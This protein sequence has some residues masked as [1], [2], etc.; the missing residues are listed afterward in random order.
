MLTVE[1]EN[2]LE[3]LRERMP[4]FNWQE[5]V[6]QVV[7]LARS[8]GIG[9]KALKKSGQRSGSEYRALFG[10]ATETAEVLDAALHGALKK[11]VSGVGKGTDSTKKTADAEERAEK[12]LRTLKRDHHLP[13]SEWIAL[14]K[15]PAAKASKNFADPVHEAAAAQDRHPRLH[16]DVQRAIELVFELA[17]QAIDLY[18]QHKRELGV[19][20]FVDQETYALQLLSRP[21]VQEQLAGELDLVLIDEFQ[22]TSPIQLAIFLRLAEVAKRSI[23]VGDQKQAI[24][25]FRGADPALMDAAIEEILGGK[26]PE[27]LPKSYRSRPGLVHFSSKLFAP[28]FALQG[29][30]AA[31]VKLVPSKEHE[32]TGLGAFVECWQLQSKNQP[33]DAAALAAA[34]KAFLDDKTVRVR[35]QADGEPRPARPGDVAI[36]CRTNDLCFNVAE[37]LA[38]LGIRPV[39]PRQGL[40]STLEGRAALAALRL[41][42]DDRDSL[43]AAELARMIDF[44]GREDDWL[45]TI[46]Q[47]P[48]EPAFASLPHI[49]RLKKE[50]KLEPDLGVIGVFDCVAECVSLA[51][52]CLRWGDADARLANLEALRS[53]TVT[54]VGGC[55]STGTGCTAAGLVAYLVGLADSE[56][57]GQGVDEDDH[58]VVVTTWHKAKGLE[59][60]VVVLFPLN[61]LDPATRALG[62]SAQTDQPK[63][64]L[65]DPLDGR[66]IRYWPNP[67]AANNNKTP[68]HDRLADHAATQFARSQAEREDLRLLYVGWT[69]ARDR[70]VL[71]GREGG[72]TGDLLQL[73]RDKN[74]P[75]VS[76]PEGRT[77]EWANQMVSVVIRAG[78][79]SAPKARRPISGNGYLAAGRARI[80]AGV[81]A[82]VRCRRL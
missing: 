81:R 47:Q 21:D 34:T 40:L 71:V 29:I 62:T 32:A 61:R 3:D 59:W 31:R 1:I 48:G 49:V 63:L 9:P 78:E 74:G 2:E 70:I 23:W 38:A 77:I 56:E 51:E 16:C 14:A 53:H 20:D 28:A 45:A 17:V 39:L 72:V 33:A 66:W 41:W 76:E 68:F 65:N 57:D 73:L 15:L 27:T 75:L 67:Y 43:A 10:K 82:T 54:Y 7:S 69:R 36:L 12:A 8:N 26:E 55:E 6:R 18:Q 35:N 50:R 25:G 79:P 52:L 22:D 19:I 80:S 4:E 11:F 58:A 24:Y 44:A 30:P 42:V 60:P 5:S 13:W 46:L 37:E 64:K